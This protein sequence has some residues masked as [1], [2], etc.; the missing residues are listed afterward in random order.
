MALPT[1]WLH[2]EGYLADRAAI[3]RSRSSLWSLPFL[4]ISWLARIIDRE[5]C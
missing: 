4:A 5:I 1:A 3:E 2:A